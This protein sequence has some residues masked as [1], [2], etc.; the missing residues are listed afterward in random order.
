M[1]ST[2]AAN[3]IYCD[4]TVIIQQML[5]VEV[6]AVV[7]LVVLVVVVKVHLQCMFTMSSCAYLQL[8]YGF[9]GM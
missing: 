9:N 3:V 6:V 8:Q 2:Y 1:R 4:Q 5:C 7:A